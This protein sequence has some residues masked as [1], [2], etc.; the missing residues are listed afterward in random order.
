MRHHLISIA[1]LS[2]D[3]LIEVR[4]LGVLRLIGLTCL[5]YVLLVII[6]RW[7]WLV[8]W[9]PLVFLGQ[10]SLYVYA[11]HTLLCYGLLAWIT[12]RLDDIGRPFQVIALFCSLGSLWIPA[13]LH[14]QW[15]NRKL[16]LI[17]ILKK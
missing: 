12:P 13:V 10:H 15:L 7:S 3:P 17:R 2:I 6:R 11:Y 9:R 14:H 5:G 1:P 8:S 16:F 4:T